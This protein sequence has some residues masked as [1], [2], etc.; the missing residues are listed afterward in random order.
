MKREIEFRGIYTSNNT[1]T[2]VYG[3]YIK[4][5]MDGKIYHEIEQANFDDHKVWTVDE[6]TIGQYTGLI[7]KNIKKIYEGD[8]IRVFNNNNGFFEVIFTNGYVGGWILHNEKGTISLGARSYNEV[9]IVGN[10]FFN[11]DLIKTV[12]K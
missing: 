7:D 5:T 11:K 6:E 12:S 4:K 2:L 10:I 3:N 8:I 1:K 9:E